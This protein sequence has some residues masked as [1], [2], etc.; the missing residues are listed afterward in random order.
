MSV[1]GATWR[2]VSGH[3]QHRGYSGA[4]GA[5]WR[6]LSGSAKVVS[7]CEGGRPASGRRQHRGNT[8]SGTDESASLGGRFINRG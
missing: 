8:V 5:T 6:D 3:P 4:D 2:Q 1:E 7:A